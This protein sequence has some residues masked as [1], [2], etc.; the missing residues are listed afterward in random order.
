MQNEELRRT[1]AQLDAERARYYE[2]YELA[3]IG[4]ITL[5]ERG[6]IVQANLTAATLLGVTRGELLNKSF[7]AFVYGE[8]QDIHYLHLKAL[9]A[10]G[11][12]HTCEDLRLVRK[13]APR[14]GCFFRRSWTKTRMAG[15]AAGS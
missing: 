7:S 13:D 15:S 11:E 6:T 12:P 10:T 3:P 4:Y 14:S 5:D 8:D 2:L 1:Q 9:L